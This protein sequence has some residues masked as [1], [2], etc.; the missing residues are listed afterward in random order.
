MLPMSLCFSQNFGENG[1]IVKVMALQV[2]VDM[3]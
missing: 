1:S 3:D 2:G